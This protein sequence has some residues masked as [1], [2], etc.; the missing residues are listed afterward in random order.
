[1]SDDKRLERIEAKIDD[2]ADHLGSIDT[3][4]LKQEVSLEH[5]IKRTDLLEEK[6]KPVE[7]HM[8]ELKGV[9]NILKVLALLATIVEG[10]HYW[11]K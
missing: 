3:T 2:L 9:I 1:M 11:N 5:H 7:T 4:L 10:L 8:A 6:M